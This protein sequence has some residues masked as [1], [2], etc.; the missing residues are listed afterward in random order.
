MPEKI[1][2]ICS[3][4]V[5]FVLFSVM[6]DEGQNLNG[7]MEMCQLDSVTILEAVQDFFREKNVKGNISNL[8]IFKAL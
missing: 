1:L 8:N 3:V 2:Y 4:L 6:D 7:I 5:F